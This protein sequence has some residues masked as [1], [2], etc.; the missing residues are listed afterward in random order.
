MDSR[1]VVGDK[2]DL[3]KIETRLS[4]DPDKKPVVYNS[5]VLDDAR[6]GNLLISMPIQE[7]K[8]IPFS[9]GTKMN[10]TF[11][12][13]S[14]LFQCEIQ[15]VGR[16]KK[17]SLFLMEVEQMS[18]LKKVQRREY[19]RLN[20]N[21]PIEYRIVNEQERNMLER[22]EPYSL[23]DIETDWKKG[24]MLDLSGGGIRFVSPNKEVKNSFLQVRFELDLT[25]DDV[26]VV[27]LFANLLR[28]EQHPNNASIYDNRLEFWRLDRAM[29]EMIVRYIFEEQRRVRS[30]QNGL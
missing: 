25:E 6:N 17:G 8:V 3:I 1:I 12:S 23:E 30:K 5:Q 27:Y 16:Y 2:I 14:G 7:G 15:V 13:K 22:G 29:Q 4:V 18:I 24:V 28:S 10:A 19:F 11:Y 9:V 21:K 20:C 26:Q